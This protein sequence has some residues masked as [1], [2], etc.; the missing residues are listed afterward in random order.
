MRDKQERFVYT[1]NLEALEN[2]VRF[3]GK[4][5]GNEVHFAFGD[6]LPWDKCD[7][8]FSSTFKNEIN[9]LFSLA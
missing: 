5:Y 6:R 8:H 1:L 9:I 7:N 4:L 2:R 3:Q